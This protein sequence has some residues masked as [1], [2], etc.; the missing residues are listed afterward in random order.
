MRNL[1]HGSE[2]HLSQIP[3]KSGSVFVPAG[4]HASTRESLGTSNFSGFRINNPIFAKFLFKKN[5][6]SI[7]VLS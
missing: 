5:E 7:A 3:N 6:N 4:T 1:T 2:S